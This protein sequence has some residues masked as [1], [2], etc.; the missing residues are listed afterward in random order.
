ME[1]AGRHPYNP[2]SCRIF[3]AS[4]KKS[5]SRILHARKMK[6]VSRWARAS[7]LYMLLRSQF[8]CKANHRM[9]RPSTVSLLL[10]SSPK[11]MIFSVSAASS[12]SLTVA[13]PAMIVQLVRICYI[14]PQNCKIIQYKNKIFVAIFTAF[15]G[16]FYHFFTKRDGLGRICRLLIEFPSV[17][18]PAGHIQHSRVITLCKMC[19]QWAVSKNVTFLFFCI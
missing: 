3:D 19:R 14:I 1:E 11:W 17:K 18:A 15:C 8:I 4:L 13:F 5:C 9:L 12:Y 6:L 7:S 16:N 2:A 10:M